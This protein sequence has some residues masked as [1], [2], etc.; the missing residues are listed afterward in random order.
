[1]SLLVWL[2]SGAVAVTVDVTGEPIHDDEAELRV[3]MARQ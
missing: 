2:A 1:V 3:H